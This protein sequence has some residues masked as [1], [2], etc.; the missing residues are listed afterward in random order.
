VSGAPVIVVLTDG[1]ANLAHY[2]DLLRREGFRVL[3]TARP[4][5]A[6]LFLAQ[7]RVVALVLRAHLLPDPPDEFLARV[8]R[9]E[10]RPFVVLTG[11]PREVPERPPPNVDLCLQEPFLYSS[12]AVPLGRAVESAGIAPP[13]PLE[14]VPSPAVATTPTRPAGV[15]ARASGSPADVPRSE[16]RVLAC[17]RR[18]AELEVDREQLLTTG[19]EMF[20]HLVDA[21]RGSIMLLNSDRTHLELARRSGFH[22]DFVEPGPIPVGDSF[23]SQVAMTARPMLVSH[24]KAPTRPCYRDLSFLI[25]P[26]MSRKLVLGVV[27]LSHHTGGTPFQEEDLRMAQLLAEQLSVNLINSRRIEDLNRMAVID[28]LTGLFNRRFFDRQMTVELE[29]ARRHDRQIT[30]ALIDI[31]NFKM[32]N[33]VNGYV[34]GDEV[35]RRC[36]EIIR[37]S[38]REVDIVTRWGGDEF[39]VLLP[40]T[41]RPP[42]AVRDGSQRINYLERVRSSI[43]EEDFSARIRGLTAK[44][45]VSTGVATF[46][47]DCSDRSSLFS[48]ANAALHRAKRG[49]N[50]RICFAGDDDDVAREAV[51]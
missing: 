48:E 44:V 43:E 34:A 18:L 30:L 10:D 3:A 14:R 26:L 27:N 25:L 12:L 51:R 11:G 22:Q 33:D 41:G 28:P 31:D 24:L 21:E 6:A 49:G 8:S 38:F 40:D 4:Y 2:M 23:A 32:I 9:F 45:T 39:A 20:L 7:H 5:E 1:E 19:L 50:N 17:T 29:R 13:T 35:I 47:V 16:L 42:R 15:A 36:A 37:R 46:P